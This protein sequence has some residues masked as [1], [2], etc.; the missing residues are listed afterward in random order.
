ML[1]FVVELGGGLLLREAVQSAE[2]PDEIDGVD[3]G[4]FSA[5]KSS[6]RIPKAMRSLGSLK[7]GM[8]TAPVGDVEICVAGG[9]AHAVEVQ[10]GGAMGSSIVSSEE[11]SSR[12][13]F[14]TR[15]QFS[16][17]GR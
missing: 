9:E 4:N 17:R 11:P 16:S 13:I 7:V 14:F 2:A 8:S 3:A 15:S 5:G 12:R 6:E 1:C 10:R